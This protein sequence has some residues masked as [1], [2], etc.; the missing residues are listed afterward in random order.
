MRLKNGENYVDRLQGG[1]ERWGDYSGAYRQG[2]EP[3]IW[4]SGFYGTS[5][6]L[7]STFTTEIFLPD[8]SRLR[9]ASNIKGNPTFCQATLQARL[10]GASPPVA[11]FWDNISGPDSLANV[12]NSSSV[13]L[14]VNDARGCR[15][16]LVIITDTIMEVSEAV[17]YPNPSSGELAVQ[18]KSEEDQ[19][20][21]VTL[22]DKSGKL[23]FAEVEREIKKG[24]N[25]VILDLFPL[26]AGTY[27]LVVVNSKTALIKKSIL[28]L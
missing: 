2:K 6:K 13:K 23:V 27:E 1:Y 25:Q 26:S 7:N 18:F 17:V 16:S 9:L 3:K 22:Y 21:R 11:Y 20:I 15:D 24:L 10:S 4:V 5:G 12:C 28:R 8:T 19:V 14:M